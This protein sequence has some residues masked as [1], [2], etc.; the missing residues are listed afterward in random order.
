VDR[1]FR[2]IQDQFVQEKR[3]RG[4]SQLTR[5]YKALFAALPTI[6]DTDCDKTAM[7]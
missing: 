7:A 3:G 4:R 6:A 5:E 2:E 1:L